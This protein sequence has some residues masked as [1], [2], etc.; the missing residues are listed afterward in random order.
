MKKRYIIL[1]VVILLILLFVGYL[2][3]KIY[4]SN[5]YNL[6]NINEF[7]KSK[8]DFV[9]ND[10][11]I[12]LDTT[13]LSEE[14][15]LIFKNIKIRNDFKDWEVMSTSDDM[16]LKTN[17]EFIWYALKQENDDKVTAAIGLAKGPTML[18]IYGSGD[19]ISSDERVDKSSN[20]TNF[21]KENKI[22]N[23]IE[24]LKYLEKTKN[25]KISILNS[26]NDMKNF[27][28]IHSLIRGT[29]NK[30]KGITL[31]NGDYEGYCFNYD[32]DTLY[33]KECNILKGGKRY[34]LTFNNSNY[35]TDE[36]INDLLN[37]LVIE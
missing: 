14:E 17:E 35:F 2:G 3:Y 31:I 34:T 7:D 23:D 26:K 4:Y 28:D 19:I 1:I 18:D 11:T 32:Y 36:K 21:F 16:E 22:T 29:Y 10:E 27:Y 6:S 37:T 15:Y 20:L 5:Y 8:E 24:L 25:D 33:I 13:R 12:T 30:V 9:I